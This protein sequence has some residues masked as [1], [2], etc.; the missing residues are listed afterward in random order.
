MGGNGTNASGF[1]ALPAGIFNGIH[2]NSLTSATYFWSTTETPTDASNVQILSLDYSTD[3]AS[4]H[5]VYK[6]GGGVYPF[7]ASCRCLKDK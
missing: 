4:I 5:P 6:L 7:L 3:G 1:T 2:W